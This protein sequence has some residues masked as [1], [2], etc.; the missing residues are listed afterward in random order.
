[1]TAKF[2]VY[3]TP[4]GK[5]RARVGR[6]ANG[7]VHSY[8]PKTT[9]EFE[10]A[11][12]WAYRVAQLG[13]FK[14]D[15]PLKMTATF[16]MPI[17]QSASKKLKKSLVGW[18][19]TKKPDTSNIIKSVEDALNNLAYPDDSQISWLDVRKVYGEEPRLEIEFTELTERRNENVAD[20]SDA[21]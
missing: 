9:V 21:E 6:N 11:I 10:N 1:M 3:E 7:F 4:K 2:V 15:T 19:H 13:V 18:W 16:Y 5:A 12:A 14:K 8:T 20:G 17:P